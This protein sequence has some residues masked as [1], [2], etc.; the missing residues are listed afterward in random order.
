MSQIG[1]GTGWTTCKQSPARSKQ[2]AMPTPHSQLARGSS[3][4]PINSIKALK[5]AELN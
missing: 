2:T 5:A 1:S 3:Q 4:C